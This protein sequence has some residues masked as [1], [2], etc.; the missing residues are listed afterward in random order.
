MSSTLP[1]QKFRDTCLIALC[2]LWPALIFCISSEVGTSFR[3]IRNEADTYIYWAGGLLAIQQFFIS[4]HGHREWLVKLSYILQVAIAV[5]GIFSYIPALKYKIFPR[6]ESL[7]IA[8]IIRQ[9]KDS[10][11]TFQSRT[12]TDSVFSDCQG[13]GA[14]AKRYRSALLTR[15]LAGNDVPA[16]DT[17]RY[18]AKVDSVLVDPITA[19][20]NRVNQFAQMV[21]DLSMLIRSKDPHAIDAIFTAYHISPT[22]KAIELRSGQKLARG[23]LRD[24]LIDNMQDL[25]PTFKEIQPPAYSKAGEQIDQ[26]IF[27]TI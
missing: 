18:I 24:F 16:K 14:S 3:N 25:T 12:P 21:F 26:L 5:V 10:T 4:N 22:A 11:D 6:D 17:L 7:L 8:E 2:I 1:N 23:L 9:V 19:T 13:T 20:C 15:L 27:T